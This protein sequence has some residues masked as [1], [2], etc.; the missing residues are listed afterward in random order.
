[1]AAKRRTESAAVQPEGPR[2]LTDHKPYAQA[3][4]QKRELQ[5]K[6]RAAQE[7]FTA[8]QAE[9]GALPDDA[10]SFNELVGSLLGGS[11]TPPYNDSQMATASPVD[12]EANATVLSSAAAT[13]TAMIGRRILHFRMIEPPCSRTQG[14]MRRGV[15]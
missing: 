5:A 14:Y 10:A 6:K 9:L 12:I 1:M 4:E 15:E 8:L 13:T 11:K 2:D 3:L 7:Q